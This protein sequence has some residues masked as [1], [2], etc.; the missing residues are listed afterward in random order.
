MTRAEL[1]ATLDDILEMP[2]GT[3]RGNEELSALQSWDSL[4]VVNFIALVHGLFNVVLPA[5][6]V[7]V[8]R[9]VPE[10]VGLVHAHLTD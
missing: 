8:C 2:I 5:Q 6:Q 3:L 7:K 9:S 1:Y 10:L 4:A